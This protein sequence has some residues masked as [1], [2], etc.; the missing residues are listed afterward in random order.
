[1]PKQTLMLGG[2]RYRY[3]SGPHTTKMYAS[4]KALDLRRKE[5]K[6]ARAI[7]KFD[8]WYIYTRG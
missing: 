7:K 1:M 5:G 2:K 3:Y 8:G 6:N 4:G